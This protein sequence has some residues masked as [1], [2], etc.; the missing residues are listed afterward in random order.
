MV[1]VVLVTHAKFGEE[2]LKSAEM[3]LGPQSHC[4]SISIEVS[5]AMEG[6]IESI[7]S[8]VQEADQG[9]GVIIL[10]DMFGGS[11]S[12]LSLSFLSSGNVEVVTGMNLPMIL[13]ILG[14]RD[15][16]IK[17]LAAEAKTAGKNGIIVAGELLRR[18]VTEG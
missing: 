1:G 4:K 2:L 13:K 18:K 10:T 16:S 9:D 5:T 11:P 14:S 8:A 12:N 6:M 7:R 15:L 3:I 17:K